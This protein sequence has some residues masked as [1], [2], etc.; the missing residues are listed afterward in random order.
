MKKTVIYSLIF[1]LILGT[2]SAAVLY[3]AGDELSFALN[4]DGTSYRVIGMGTCKDKDLVIPSEYEGLPVTSIAT[5]AF[6]Q[7]KNLVS[8]EIP[9]S[10]TTLGDFVFSGCTSLKSVYFDT[11]LKSMGKGA[12]YNCTSLESISLPPSL[13][14]IGDWAFWNCLSLT[15]IKIPANVSSV[16][17]GI[18]SGCGKLSD[19]DISSGISSLTQ[20][21]FADCISLTSINLPSN[22]ASIGEYAFADCYRLSDIFFV[23]SHT[24]ISGKAFFGV[25]AKA[26]YSCTDASWSGFSFGGYGGTLTWV[27]H[28]NIVHYPAVEATQTTQGN[29]E[30]WYC[31]D[32]GRYYSDAECTNEIDPGQID[33]P[34]VGEVKRGDV[35]GNGQKNEDD[36][37]RALYH[38][39]FGDTY[40]VNQDLDFDGNGAENEDDVIRLLYNIF[41][42]ET[43]P[44]N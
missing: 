19:V 18:F 26:H 30:Y 37:I 24:S 9:A 32:C 39:F 27:S 25:S 16:G 7:N 4:S 43:Y 20:Y 35:D 15:S 31:S 2:L 12:F 41:F 8:V 28:N 11:G 23:N 38:L 21:M 40:R 36:V 10:I 42:G 1:I 3:A 22:V 33:I 14:V 5:R 6:E 44:L 13:S 34:V 29:I 17:I